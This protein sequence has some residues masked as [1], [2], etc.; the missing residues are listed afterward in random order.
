MNKTD[1]YLPLGSVVLLRGASKR[2][3][4]IGF[5]SYSTSDVGGKMYDY[6]GCLYPEGII[7]SEETALFNHEDINKV[8]Y[9][10]YSD[11]EEKEFKKNLGKLLQET[12]LKEE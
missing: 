3:M 5:C 4:I 10:G 8:Y 9:M 12:M 2:L 11:K 6:I 7:S 1:K